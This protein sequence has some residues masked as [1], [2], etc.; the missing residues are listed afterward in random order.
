M[1]LAES[2]PD[3]KANQNF[4]ELSQQLETVEEDIAN[5]RKYYNGAVRKYNMTVQSV[6]TN[7]IAGLFHFET[8]PMYEVE[9]ESERQNVKVSFQ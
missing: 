9:D 7:I 6:P 5:A 1:A 4:Q 2:Y 8:K 3:L